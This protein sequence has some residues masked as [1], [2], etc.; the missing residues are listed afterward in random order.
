MSTILF[1]PWLIAEAGFFDLFIQQQPSLSVAGD[2]DEVNE[3][4]NENETEPAAND[5][6]FDLIQYWKGKS[7]KWPRHCLVA[8]NIFS[9]PTNIPKVFS[10]AWRTFED[11]CCVIMDAFIFFVL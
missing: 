3:H 1:Q 6:E 7:T 8:R 11:R 5:L 9:M 10:L 4:L 2:R